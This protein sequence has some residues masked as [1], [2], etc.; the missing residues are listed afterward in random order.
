MHISLPGGKALSI[1]SVFGLLVSAAGWVTSPMALALIPA[2][3]AAT[4]VAI[5]TAILTL[6][7]ELIHT[8]A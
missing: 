1:G 3:Y 6:S 2:H 5:G 8:P 4:V 7:K